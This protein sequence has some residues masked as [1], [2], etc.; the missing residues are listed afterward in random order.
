MRWA[1][2]GLGVEE[3]LVS[4]VMSVCAGAETVA[5]TVCG[6]SGGFEVEVGM[7][8]GSALGPLLFVIFMWAMSREFGVALPWGPLCWWLGCDG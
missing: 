7:C 1:M 3:W 6:D 4:A 8:R 5:G 2:H